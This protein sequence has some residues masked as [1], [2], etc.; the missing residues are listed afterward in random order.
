MMLKFS[1]KLMFTNFST[2]WKVALYYLAITLILTALI[3][4]C[5][6]IPLNKF[7]GE[8]AN[9]GFF[10]DLGQLAGS[11]FNDTTSAEH[12]DHI[13]EDL[14]VMGTYIGDNLGSFT[15]LCIMLGIFYI[16]GSFLYGLASLPTTIILN[17]NMNSQAKLSFCGTFFSQLGHSCKFT[18]SKMLLAVPFSIFNAA[19][20]FALISL[21]QFIGIFALVIASL[22]YVMLY[23]FKKTLFSGWLPAKI[24]EGEKI[25]E[26]LKTGV[27]ASFGRFWEVF[28]STIISFYI[29]M[30]LLLVLGILTF[31]VSTFIFVPACAVFSMLF[32]LVMYYGATARRYFVDYDTI[33]T[34]KTLRDK[35]AELVNSVNNYTGISES[36]MLSSIV[37]NDKIIT[38][39][40]DIESE[41]SD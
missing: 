36:D 23:A 15:Y 3:F 34:P 2:T 18:L 1:F 12:L 40:I 33:I 17:A 38:K 27:K 11:F 4:S 6:F 24:L 19:V 37:D 5:I 10:D 28:S 30:A 39:T 9:T 25:F 14:S 8:L 31:G 16:I 35:N 22:V 41:I 7:C 13:S 20:A 32:N 21:T 26:S 29:F